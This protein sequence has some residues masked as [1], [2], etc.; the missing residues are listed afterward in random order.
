VKRGGRLGVLLALLLLSAPACDDGPGGAAA[1]PG[2]PSLP[3]PGEQAPLEFQVEATGTDSTVEY[4]RPSA[5]LART[6]TE[7]DRAAR[8]A[9]APGASSGL[10]AWD[11]YPRR[12]LIAVLAGAQPD[13]GYEIV[14]A[15]V[16][17]EEEGRTLRVTGRIQRPEGFF[18]QV[19]SIPW[20]LLSVDPSVVSLV[21]R[22]ILAL[23]E[24]RTFASPCGQS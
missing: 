24:K 7:G 3:A 4:P 2:V 21:D 20:V 22:C 23:E 6:T 1:E 14:V 13:A 18:A 5:L 8:R 10:R 17:L 19:I 11:E 9:V 15:D 16:F 12:S